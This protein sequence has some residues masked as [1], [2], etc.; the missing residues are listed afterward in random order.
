MHALYE[1]R[2]TWLQKERENTQL[3]QQYVQKHRHK[4]SPEIQ[5][6]QM[7]VV[8]ITTTDLFQVVSLDSNT[9]LSSSEKKHS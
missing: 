5:C 8:I 2:S 1:L 3:I 9:M 4:L 6:G 7:P